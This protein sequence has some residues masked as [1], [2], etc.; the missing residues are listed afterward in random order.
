MFLKPCSHV[1]SCQQVEV[2]PLSADDWEILVKK[3]KWELSK[4][5]VKLLQNISVFLSIVIYSAVLISVVQ[6][7]SSVMHIYT[8]FCSLPLW[9]ILGGCI[10]SPVPYSKTLFLI[11]SM[12]IVLLAASLICLLLP[13]GMNFLVSVLALV[14]HHLWVLGLHNDTQSLK[15]RSLL[16][17]PIPVSGV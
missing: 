16:G 17:S 15:R 10:Q 2:E 5:K 6:Q 11:C 8:F 12:E 9:F 13:S 3:T 14:M 7:S 1:A 4:F